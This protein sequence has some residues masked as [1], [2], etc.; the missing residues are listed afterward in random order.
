MSIS[1][2]LPIC[3]KPTVWSLCYSK[4]LRPRTRISKPLPI[5]CKPIVWNLYASKNLSPRTSSQ[6]Y[7]ICM[8]HANDQLFE[9]VRIYQKVFIV[10]VS[11]K[12][13][14][15]KT[16]CLNFML[17]R[18]Y[19]TKNVYSKTTTYKLR[20]NRL[21]LRQM[22]IYMNINTSIYTCTEN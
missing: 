18:I 2:P 10:F 21:K 13:P 1:K 6:D 20:I 19:Y 8:L 3:C 14:S 4:N 17:M 9:V 11:L 15:L 22:R 5:C 7:C 12:K 16:S